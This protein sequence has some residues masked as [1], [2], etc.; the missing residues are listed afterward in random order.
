M[1]NL[2]YLAVG[3]YGTRHMLTDANKHPRGQLLA[4]C[5]SKHA[6][7]MYIDSSSGETK[8]IGYI[9]GREWYTIYTVGEWK[10]N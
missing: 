10:G 5:G 8:H 3:C 4:K 2:G 7:K 6:E 1:D 9:V